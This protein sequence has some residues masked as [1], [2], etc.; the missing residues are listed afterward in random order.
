MD[1]NIHISGR[2]YIRIYIYI[3]YHIIFNEISVGALHTHVSAIGI[4]AASTVLNG[5]IPNFDTIYDQAYIG[6]YRWSLYW[7]EEVFTA[8]VDR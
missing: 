3:S 6:R 8:R 2:Q 5:P 4:R 7:R 1:Y